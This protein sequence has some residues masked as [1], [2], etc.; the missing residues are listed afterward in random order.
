MRYTGRSLFYT[1]AIIAISIIFLS[2]RSMAAQSETSVSCDEGVIGEPLSMVYGDY[3]VNCAI[4]FATDSDRFSFDGAAGELVRINVVSTTTNMD[5]FLEVRDPTGA[6]I[7]TEICNNVG[8]SFSLDVT[9]P[10]SGTYFLTLSDSGT[11]EAGNYTMQLE[12]I[13]PS[14]NLVQLDYGSS[15]IDTVSPQTD[16]DHYYFY[17]TAG[18]SIRFNALS[19]ATNMDPTIE[20]RDPNGTL[21][22]NGATDGASCTNVGC[23]F[24][25][26][27]SPALTGTYSVLFYDGGTNESGSYQLSL[28]CVAGSCD[29]NGDGI[30]DV[31]APVISYDTP[32]IDSISPAVD[33]DFFIFNATAGTLV[34]FNA[35]STTTNMDP[36]IEVRDPNGILVVNGATDG[37]SCT[38]VGCSFSVDISPELTGTYSVL[39]Y[40]GGT[41]EAG[42]YQLGLWCVVGPCDSDGN[43]SPDPVAPVISYVTPVTDSISSAVDGDIFRFNATA[44]TSIR[45]N[46]LSTTTNMDPTI[47]VRDPDGNLLLNGSVDGASCTNVGCSFSADIS[48]ALTG[49]YS[50]LFYD[51]G[52]NEA[53]DYQLSLWC[54][55][56]GCDSDTDGIADGDRQIVGYGENI[57]TKAISPAVDADFYIFNGTMGDQIRINV[58][59]TTTNMDPTIEVYDP[60]GTRI[61]NGAADGA[62]CTNV[63]CSFSVDLS[64]ALTGTYSVIF[65]DSGTNENGDYQFS[66]QCLFS[67]GGNCVDL[68]PPLNC[69]DNCSEISNPDQL[70]TNGDGFG[71]VCDGDLDNDGA[72]NF[73]DLNIMKSVFFTADADADLNGDGAVNFGDLNILKSMFFKS[74]G[75]SCA[76]PNVP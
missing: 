70:D 54:V 50:V 15:E 5:P 17:G 18:T 76:A 49:T 51:G 2:G 43:G 38:N 19:T 37:A 65:Y 45:F 3:T 46:A 11:N 64:P 6:V 1:L 72:V 39:F 13:L 71:N 22:L 56:G 62:S 35:L 31:D 24:S 67:P 69:G 30:V 8:C 9:L 63:G 47:E 10:Q 23:S 14:P 28:W 21:V 25:V 27:L 57:S 29:S 58:L 68:A 26:D 41:N 42:G 60:D 75:P 20:V 34:R 74:P 12:R 33:G 32:V 16:V 59:S 40:D 66:L 55:L 73:G 48:P 44:G 36:T 7:D 53:G 52:T 4:N 61:L